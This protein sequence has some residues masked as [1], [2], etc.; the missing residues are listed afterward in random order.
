MIKI[1]KMT[2]GEIPIYLVAYIVTV[3]AYKPLNKF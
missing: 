3:P 1:S 2:L